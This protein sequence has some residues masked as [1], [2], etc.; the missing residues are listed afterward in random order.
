[1]CKPF[2]GIDMKKAK[3]YIII[4]G[5]AIVLNFF[6]WK[7]GSDCLVDIINSKS[8]S[9]VLL[10]LSFLGLIC[11]VL[12]RIMRWISDLIK[13]LVKTQK[14]KLGIGVTAAVLIFGTT[15][16]YNL[17]NLGS[18]IINGNSRQELCRK[19]VDAN[20][21][22]SGTKANNLTIKEYN[23]I[24]N[25]ITLPSLPQEAYEIGYLYSYD[26]F[27][28][29]YTKEVIYKVPQTIDVRAYQDNGENFGDGRYIVEFDEYNLV[30]YS[31]YNK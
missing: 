16:F 11:L 8:N 10:S 25:L 18:R 14:F 22:A 20:Y 3:K 29:D 26:G 17:K 28:T 1:M 5:C 4:V 6:L 9:S 19:I 31:E 30:T 27:L 13:S 21:L 24:R 12:I 2:L 15:T 23:Q 7:I